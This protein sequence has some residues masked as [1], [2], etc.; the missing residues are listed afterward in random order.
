M[1]E[2]CHIYVLDRSV[3]F[4][5]THQLLLGSTSLKRRL[6]NN[7]GSR[8]IFVVTLDKFIAFCKSTLSQ[9][10]SFDILFVA[11]LTILMLDSLFNNCSAGVGSICMKISLTATLLGSWNHWLNLSS[12]S[13][14]TG[15]LRLC[16]HELILTTIVIWHILNRFNNSKNLI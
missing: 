1:L 8:N 7:F 15:S 10:F 5:F 12:S 6:L 13:S 2:L 9:K 4:N 16:P 14:S 3:N 11:Y